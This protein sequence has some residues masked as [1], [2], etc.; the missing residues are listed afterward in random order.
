[1][2]SREYTLQLKNK[3]KNFY[4]MRAC[5]AVAEAAK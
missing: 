3:N 4:G 1:M 5:H 2:L